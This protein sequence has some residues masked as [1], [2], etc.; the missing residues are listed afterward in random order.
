MRCGL[1]GRTPVSRS[2]ASL[3]ARSTASSGAGVGVL[4]C[5]ATADLRGVPRRAVTRPSSGRGGRCRSWSHG[6]LRRE[7][8]DEDQPP[9]LTVRTDHRL[10]RRDRFYVDRLWRRY[11]GVLQRIGLGWRLQL[12]HMADP[13]GVVALRRMPQTEVSDF[14]EAAR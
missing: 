4:V 7:P 5:E 9:L 10:D 2:E 12:Q 1:S 11:A 3:S 13:S 6:L 8:A 14:V